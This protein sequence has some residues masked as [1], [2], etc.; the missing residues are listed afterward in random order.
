MLGKVSCLPL[1]WTIEVPNGE[2][3]VKVTVG[4]PS[5]SSAVSININGM[6]LID[7]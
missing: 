5:F 6:I 3:N 4:D 2:Y 7:A 1:K